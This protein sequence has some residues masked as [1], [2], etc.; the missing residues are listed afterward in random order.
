MTSPTHP[1]E[2]EVTP[3]QRA[4]EQVRSHLVA[5]RGGAPFLSP[6]D[7]ALLVRWLDDAVPVHA[8]C[9]ALERAVEAR[10]KRPT[11]V[12]LRLGHAKRHLGKVDTVRTV[13]KQSDGHPLAPL[14]DALPSTLNTLGNALVA[15]DASDPDALLDNAIATVTAFHDACWRAQTPAERRSRL[16]AAKLALGDLLNDLDEATAHDLCEA[17]ARDALRAEQPLLTAATLW[18]LVYG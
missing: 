18:T 15:L 17:S 3:H 10:R 4:A 5:L 16:Q 11:R 8:I 6:T 13:A 12:P 7:A 9:C 1:A 2:T 14:A